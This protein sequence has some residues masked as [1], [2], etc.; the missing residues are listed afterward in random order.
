MDGEASPILPYTA[1]LIREG[2]R[3]SLHGAGKTGPLLSGSQP[4]S[5]RRGYWPAVDRVDMKGPLPLLA[6]RGSAG[7]PPTE[8]NA[9]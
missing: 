7:S 5:F 8:D 3:P 4:V 9:F 6:L 1:I 2:T